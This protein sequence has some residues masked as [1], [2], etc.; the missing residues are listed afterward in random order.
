MKPKKLAIICFKG[1]ES[2]LDWAD[3]IEEYE[4]KKFIVTR[5]DQIDGAIDWADIVF[6]EW[7]NELAVYVSNYRNIVF[8]DKVI[9]RCHSYEILNGYANQINWENIDHVIFIAN[10]VKDIFER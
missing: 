5:Q 10:H 2:F 7:M 4:V 6:I 8:K 9:V 3:H 1:L